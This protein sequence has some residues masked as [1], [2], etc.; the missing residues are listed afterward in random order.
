MLVLLLGTLFATYVPLEKYARAP[1]FSKSV[2]YF[3]FL[4]SLVF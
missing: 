1:F 3:N 4:S 2:S